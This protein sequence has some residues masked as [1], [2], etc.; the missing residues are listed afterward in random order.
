MTS[1]LDT[2]SFS[3]WSLGWTEEKNLC[4]SQPYLNLFE[5]ETELPVQ[6]VTRHTQ[7]SILRLYAAW[8]AVMRT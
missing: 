2:D 4:I 5:D 6:R 3:H 1:N 8:G 7:P